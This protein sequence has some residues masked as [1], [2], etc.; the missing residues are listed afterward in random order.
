MLYIANYEF[1]GNLLQITS[2]NSSFYEAIGGAIIQNCN[3]KH[4]IKQQEQETVK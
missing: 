4:Q 2:T 1:L 3:P